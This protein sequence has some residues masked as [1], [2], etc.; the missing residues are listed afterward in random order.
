MARENG[1][2]RKARMAYNPKEK[3][4]REVKKE[5][6]KRSWEGANPLRNA[7]EPGK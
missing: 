3:K 4:P 1:K 2:H 5:K 6:M 7:G